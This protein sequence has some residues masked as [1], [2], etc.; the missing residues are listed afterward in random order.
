[1]SLKN[2]ASIRKAIAHFLYYLNKIASKILYSRSQLVN[3][4]SFIELDKLKKKNA[5]LL[6]YDK[7]K[8]RSILR[9]YPIFVGLGTDVA[10]NLRC[11]MC[12]R[13][14]KSETEVKS[15][16][17]IEEKY[18]IKFVEQ[19]F[20]TAKILQLNTAGEPL[21]SRTFDLELEL[22][23]KYSVKLELITNGTLLNIKNARFKKLVENS[24]L[25]CFS[26]DSPVKETYES[27]RIGAD[28]DQAVENMR[29]FQKYRNQLPK[30]KRPAF[31]IV[32]VL[33]KRN[34]QEVFQMLKFAKEIG[35]DSLG[36][37]HLYVHTKDMEI[38]SLDNCKEEVNE[39]LLSAVQL[40]KEIQINLVIPPLY[41]IEPM[42]L[43]IEKFS[44]GFHKSKFKKIIQRCSFLWERVYIDGNANIIPC[45][46]PSHP[47][48]GSIKDNNFEEIWNGRLY[49]VMRN[50]FTGEGFYPLCKKC[51]EEG[52]LNQT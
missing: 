30:T 2:S 40:A 19:V 7:E 5:I 12:I 4:K 39:M 36:I 44:A 26:F 21:M 8:K 51:A 16:P 20:P 48:V 34:L 3:K 37:S 32:M 14:T 46:E 10:C 33:M 9:A 52:Y 6:Q 1:M 31:N 45:C 35:A 15:G 25:I 41:E 29:L 17:I 47:V 49:Q 23:E 50:T 27:I 43:P 38:E 28:F 22:A 42:A 18:L 24:H 11:V 13:Q